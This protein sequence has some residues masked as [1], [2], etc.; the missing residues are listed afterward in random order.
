[1]KNIFLCCT[2]FHGL[3]IF[4][5]VENAAEHFSSQYDRLLLFEDEHVNLGAFFIGEEKT[6]SLPFRNPLNTSIVLEHT[7]DHR[8]DKCF[9]PYG[10]WGNRTIGPG[11]RDTLV[12]KIKP[13]LRDHEEG[14]HKEHWSFWIANHLWCKSVI[15]GYEILLDMGKLEASKVVLDT[16][17]VH[18]S[19]LFQI[20]VTNTGTHPIT[21][22]PWE[23]YWP[24]F[25]TSLN[26]DTITFEPGEVR[27]MA[28]MFYAESWLDQSYR[29]TYNSNRPTQ[30]RSFNFHVST[31]IR[32][33][34]FPIIEF[35]S[36]VKY[37]YCDERGKWKF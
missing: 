35:D 22:Y 1:M 16:I 17:D 15:L 36:L 18:D 8:Y 7:S 6:V 28:Y 21:I 23:R 32:A 10:V 19:V 33:D 20:P 34:S 30:R 3:A 29:M 2:F 14:M 37:L 27:N 31:Y 25:I 5:N 11:E 13:N 26:P 12:L 9:E 4:A 24:R